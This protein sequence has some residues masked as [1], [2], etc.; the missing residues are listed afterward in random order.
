MNIKIENRIIDIIKSKKGYIKSKELEEEGISR[1][2]LSELSRDGVITKIKRGLYKLSDM[3]AFEWES[4][5][6]VCNS[7]PNG[8]ICLESALDY[9][10]LSTINPG[11]VF[12]AIDNNSKVKLPE[13]PPV[14]LYYFSKTQFMY[15]V[16]QVET[17]GGI[18]RIYS[19]EKTICDCI[20]HRN[21]IGI[22]I[23][24]E[25]VKNYLKRKDRDLEALMKCAKACRV[26]A[27]LQKY[28][29]VLI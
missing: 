27:I 21:K 1:K 3:P 28:L 11:Q 10:E 13:Y 25:V 2:Y 12:I 15:A 24:K 19:R 16:E 29:E 5:V 23:V 8:V 20:R 7:I 9:Y 18:I 14:K 4:F 6:D 17:S 22:D 26:E